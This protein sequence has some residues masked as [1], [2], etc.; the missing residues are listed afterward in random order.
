MEK[1]ACWRQ[2]SIWRDHSLV[3]NYC[4]HAFFRIVIVC[5]GTIRSLQYQ[6]ATGRC[7]SERD[8]PGMPFRSIVQRHHRGVCQLPLGDRPCAGVIEARGSRIKLRVLCG[9]PYDNR[10][11]SDYVYG[12]FI[13]YGAVFVLPQRAQRHRQVAES[14]SLQRNL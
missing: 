7:A 8:M 13:H 11:E 3:H 2:E 5:P 4:V 14:H 9:L 10:L 12:S 6:F 1:F